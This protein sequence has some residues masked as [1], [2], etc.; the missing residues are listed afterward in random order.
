MRVFGLSIQGVGALLAIGIAAGC[1]GVTT[2][3]DRTTGLNDAVPNAKVSP[4]PSQRLLYVSDPGTN[5]VQVFAVGGG[6]TQTLTGFNAPQGECVDG[7]GNVYVA[8]RLAHNVLEYAHGGTSPIKT[9]DDQG[10]LPVGCAIRGN[11]V[12]VANLKPIGA[13]PGSI[14]VYVGS[15]TSPT[16]VYSNPTVFARINFVGYKGPTLYLAGTT[17]SG[18]YQF[19]KMVPSGT[20]SGLTINGGAFGM[21]SMVGGVQHPPSTNYVALGST[22]S[23]Y[24]YHVSIGATSAT[25]IGKTTLTGTCGASTGFFIDQPAAGQRILYDP[26][27]CNLH[28]VTVHKYPAGGPPGSVYTTNLVNP[29]ATVI[30]P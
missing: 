18:A 13:G 7:A 23:S 25:T 28:S 3:A 11:T 27:P 14:A 26:E 9:L 16:A 22:A 6:L 21:P 30:S 29:I 17:P 20:I 15:A 24:I 1:S 8:N 19:G 5:S 4:N 2:Q 12:A 10:Q